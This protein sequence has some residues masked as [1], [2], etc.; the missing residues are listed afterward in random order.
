MGD[1]ETV[2]VFLKGHQRG[3]WAS[4]AY[5]VSVEKPYLLFPKDRK[6]VLKE[7]SETDYHKHQFAFKVSDY[8]RDASAKKYALLSARLY[9]LLADKGYF[10]PKTVFGVYSTGGGRDRVYRIFSIMPKL[11][12]LQKSDFKSMKET[13]KILVDLLKTHGMPTGLADF[14]MESPYVHQNFMRDE[15]GAVYAVDAGLWPL[16]EDVPTAKKLLEIP[17]IKKFWAGWKKLGKQ[18]K[19]P[20]EKPL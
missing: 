4:G 18:K 19:T 11:E 10:H 16:R 15:K 5:D 20:K 6:A 1:I 13:A 14:L 2:E 9:R 17:E 3:P 12:P 8:G 7:L